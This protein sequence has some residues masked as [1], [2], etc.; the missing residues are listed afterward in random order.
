MKRIVIWMLCLGFCLGMWGCRSQENVVWETVSDNLES[1]VASVTPPYSMTFGVPEDAQLVEAFSGD[2][3][4][5]YQQEEGKYEIVAQT[6]TA[7]SLDSLL[8]ELTGFSKD[9][10]DLVETT[11]FSMPRYDL[12]WCAADDEG[13]QVS[14]A[15]ILD[16][17]V[18]YYV[19]CA[20]ARED[21]VCRAELEEVFQSLGLYHDEGF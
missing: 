8:Q 2:S 1:P 9:E 21:A 6:L 4:Q 17:G 16:D 3:Q 19:L 13:Q 20:T 11:A 5:V 12:A 14:R 18:Y 7:D 10:L 15:T